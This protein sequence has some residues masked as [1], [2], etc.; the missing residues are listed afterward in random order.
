[1]PL[2]SNVYRIITGH[3]N[4][5]IDFCSDRIRTYPVQNITILNQGNTVLSFMTIL[6]IVWRKQRKGGSGPRVTL[7]IRAPH[8]LR[9]FYK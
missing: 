3:S 6:T 1:M 8:R 7:L 2:H 5:L 4:G 9:L